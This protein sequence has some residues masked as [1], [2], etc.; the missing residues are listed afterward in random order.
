M[1]YI[2]WGSALLLAVVAACA[3]G[4]DDEGRTSSGSGLGTGGGG[5]ESGSGGTIT[6]TG[7][8]FE[9]ESGDFALPDYGLDYNAQPILGALAT[10][11]TCL[12]GSSVSRHVTTDL[13]GDGKPDLV[14]TQSCDDTSAGISH[15]LVH[16]NSGTGFAETATEWTLPS[17]GLDYYS[18]PILGSTG[19][20]ATCTG[21]STTVVYT[22]L[23]LTGDGRPDLV[24]TKSCTDAD[25]GIGKWLVYENTGSGFSTTATE[26][27]LPSYG[28]DSGS[29][30][31]L[32]Q[33]SPNTTCTSGSPVRGATID[34]TGDG[35]PELV[36]TRSCTATDTGLSN[37]LVY[38]ND[39]T[40]FATSPTEWALPS[41][42]LD[43]GGEPILGSVAGSASCTTAGATTFGLLDLGGDGPPD[44]VVTRH[45]F[46]DAD[47][48]LS[49]W[50]V[51]EN[52]GGG[53]A[54]TGTE[55]E[56]PSYGLDASGQPV[57]SAVSGSA[58]C[59]TSGAKTFTTLDMTGDKRPELVVTSNC[60]DDASTGRSHWLIHENTGNGFGEAAEWELPNYGLDAAGESMLRTT[61]SAGSCATAGTYSFATFDIDGNGRPDLVFSG[62]CGESGVGL[63][64]WMVHSNICEQ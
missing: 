18:E 48:G 36:I 56:L 38:D 26:W 43:S 1:R 57:L 39:G 29:Q 55:W 28:L 53:F 10:T 62:H 12:D 51:H 59:T 47:T 50:L 11:A 25:A 58:S 32:G 22:T 52:S 4:V 31:V 27:T 13:T 60:F 24:V 42:G 41:Y 3:R 23:D 7:V 2:A 34:V 5:G 61:A 21:G 33:V 54:E 45:C 37:W 64:T 17:Y 9:G 30:P 46:D 14:V 20:V 35:R 6:C 44:L 40:G 8:A 16:E 19:A 15:W 49:R 63:S